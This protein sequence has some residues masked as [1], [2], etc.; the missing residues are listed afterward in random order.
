VDEGW[1]Q[2][3]YRRIFESSSGYLVSAYQ[4]SREAGYDGEAVFLRGVRDDEVAFSRRRG[5]TLANA[6]RDDRL[7]ALFA[8]FEARAEDR[9][10]VPRDRTRLTDPASL[11]PPLLLTDFRDARLVVEVT[12]DGQVPSVS[13]ELRGDL[14]RQFAHAG[15][16]LPV[17]EV[18]TARFGAVA[19]TTVE[20]A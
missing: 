5:T 11:N 9:R 17:R 19:E 12:M 1:I 7:S 8:A 2:Y 18:E 20:P 6:T 16:Q 14:R 3:R 4:P 15:R 10:R 13:R